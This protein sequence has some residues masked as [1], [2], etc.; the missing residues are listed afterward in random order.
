MIKGVNKQIIDVMQTG[1]QYFER[2]L[3]FVRP[4]FSGRDLNQLKQEADRMISSLGQP[5]SFDTKTS[6][7]LVSAKTTNLT[8]RKRARKAKIVRV[9]LAVFLLMVCAAAIVWLRQIN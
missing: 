7:Q 9:I 2:A 6:P 1:S 4:E 5:P 8:L 3:L